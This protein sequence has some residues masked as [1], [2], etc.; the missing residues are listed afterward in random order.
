MKKSLLAIAA[1][2]AFAGAAQA[3]SSV[4]VYGIMDGS[5]TATDNATTTT[6]GAKTTVKGR[7]TVNGDGALS[8]SRIGFKGVEDIG[9]GM[10]AEFMLEYDLVNIGNGGNGNDIAVSE[11]APSTGTVASGFGARQSWIGLSNKMGS[12]RLGRQEES[13]HGVIAGNSAGGANNITGALYSK[14]SNS[15]VNSASVR[16]HDVYVNQAITYISPKV[17]GF[18]VQVQTSQNAYSASES[19]RLTGA[20]ETGG[21]VTFDGVKNLKVAYGVAQL[22]FDTTTASTKTFRQ[23]LGANYNFGIAQVFVLG[24]QNKVDDKSG[25]VNLSDTKAYELGVKAPITPK[26]GVWASMFTG[27]RNTGTAST[28][29]TLAN[30]QTAAASSADVGGFQL[31]STYSLSKRTTAYAIYGQQNIKGKDAAS[32]AKVE[33]SAYAVGLRHTF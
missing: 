30:S 12:L 24:T 7:N 17:S 6:A 1:M 28:T 3:Q 18:Q 5:Y 33:S 9:G 23:S 2:T 16:P 13:I 11:A 10:K 29:T 8:T 4:T 27:N 21:S 22:G 25:G 31:G 26:I 19:T 20:N 15:D 14:G 32:G